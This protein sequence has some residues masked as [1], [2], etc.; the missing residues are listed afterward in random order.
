MSEC[1]HEWASYAGNVLCVKCGEPLREYIARLRKVVEEA[2]LMQTA[3]G[4]HW[5]CSAS[6][7]HEAVC[8]AADA[9]GDALRAL[10]AGK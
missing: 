3:W 10:D 5:D 6:P 4:E 8:V 2:R 9:L 7:G 1:E